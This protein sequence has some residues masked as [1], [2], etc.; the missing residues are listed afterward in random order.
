[1][2]FLSKHFATS[3]ADLSWKSLSLMF[4]TGQQAE[5][6]LDLLKGWQGIQRLV[7]RNLWETVIGGAGSHTD[8]MLNSSL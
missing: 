7:L 8:K 4:A 2:E 6:F 1:M 3:F 5:S